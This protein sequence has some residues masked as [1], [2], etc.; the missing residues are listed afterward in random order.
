MP[1]L[2]DKVDLSSQSGKMQ[3]VAAAQKAMADFKSSLVDT[4]TNG[5]I[6]NKQGLISLPGT[7]LD[8]FTR[9]KFA[10]LTQDTKK[11]FMDIFSSL[12][13]TSGGL[14]TESL[15]NQTFGNSGGG[16]GQMITQI[17][18]NMNKYLA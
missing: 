1:G 12:S 15:I 2:S 13:K 17:T 5:G 4:L 11:E 18:E 6:A 7:P 14:A 16:F 9:T 8:T 10:N 3:A